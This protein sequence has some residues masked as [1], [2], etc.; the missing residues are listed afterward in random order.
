[1]Y[2]KY[3]IYLVLLTSIEC[4][5][6]KRTNRRNQD[7]RKETCISGG[8]LKL[9]QEWSASFKQKNRENKAL[10]ERNWN[11]FSLGKSD[12]LV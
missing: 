7:D 8:A 9:N 3:W 5:G 4:Y 1:M 10:S 2:F 12:L 6:E 11:R